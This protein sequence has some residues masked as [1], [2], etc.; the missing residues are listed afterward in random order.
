MRRSLDCLGPTGQ[1]HAAFLLAPAS[2]SYL[3]DAGTVD[4]EFKA[5]SSSEDEA[6][7]VEQFRLENIKDRPPIFDAEALHDAVEDIA[8]EEPQDWTQTQARPMFQA[9]RAVCK[10]PLAV[11]L[12]QTERLIFLRAVASEAL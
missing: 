5:G 2:M 7:G 9:G 12:A 11:W 3:K 8:W 1:V 10:A 6:A 4:H